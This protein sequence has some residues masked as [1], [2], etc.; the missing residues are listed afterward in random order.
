[1]IKS[2]VKVKRG[3]PRVFQVLL[4]NDDEGEGVEVEE[5]ELVDFGRVEE[6]LAQGGSVFI[7]SKRS[8]KI[9]A[10]KS[11]KPRGKSNMRT[12]TVFH[13]NGI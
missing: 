2:F 1:M 3:R 11:K 9:A 4:L 8:Q 6:H 7:T 13:L 5:A 10:P 12:V